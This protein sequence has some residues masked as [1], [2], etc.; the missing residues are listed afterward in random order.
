MSNTTENTV[1]HRMSD[2]INAHDVDAITSGRHA[3]VKC[4]THDYE[5][6]QPLHP[7][8]GFIGIAQVRENSAPQQAN[9]H[10]C[11]K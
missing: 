5:G 3:N 8:S 7:E 11:Q 4:F 6:E 2:A 1:L 9:S 10:F